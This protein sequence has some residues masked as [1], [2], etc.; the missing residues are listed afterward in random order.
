M[1]ISK[2]MLGTVQFGLNYGIANTEGQPSYAKSRDIISAAFASGVNCLDTAAAYGNSEEVIGRALKELGLSAK[3]LV[4]TKVPI[5]E[6]LAAK[7]AEDF[8]FGSIRNSMA[9][10]G[11]DILDGCLFHREDDVKYMDILL[12]ARDQGL[13]KK[14]GISL[15]STAFIDAVLGS[16][17]EY[18]QLPF[19]ILDK[20]LTSTGFIGKAKSK[21]MALFSRSVYL[22]GLLLM[23]EEKISEQ[24]KDVI[25]VRRKLEA[26]AA[27][28]GMAAAELYMRFVL[29][30][31]E[32]DSILTGVDNLE[33][34]RENVRLFSKGPLDSA[35]M[36]RIDEIV[37]L[38]PEKIVRPGCW[39]RWRKK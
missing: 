17:A 29:T 34:L 39:E 3:V 15:D 13:I 23:S 1:K 10:L 19:N 25:P 38:F 7:A 33:Q 2:L 11:K 4:I 27:E 24:L 26:L 36:R 22:Q 8:I 37:P 30:H 28:K 14:A 5:I 32:I 6:N 35:T 18:V 16:G 21:G 9:K 12:K 20:R 31:G